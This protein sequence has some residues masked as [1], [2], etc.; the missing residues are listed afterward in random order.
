MSA[1]AV[2]RSLRERGFGGAR[3]AV[4]LGSGLGAFADRVDGARALAFDA[5]DGMPRSAVPGHAGR[6][7]RGELGGVPVL[8]QQG[9]VH[10]YEGWSAAEAT[11]AVR[12]FAALGVEALLLTNA[13]GGVR[14]EWSP[15]T[16]MRV[17]DHLNLTGRVP[18]ADEPR[19]R[20]GAVYDPEV[21]ARIDAA[22]RGAS[23]ALERGV[24]AG[25]LGPSYETPAEIRM[26]RWMG[27]DAVGMST[28]LEAV[29]AAQAGLR[30]AA[31]ACITN[32]A[33]G[34]GT[35]PLAH[36]EVI[37]TG[38]AAAATFERLLAAAIPALRP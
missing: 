6:F 32:H 4:V 29:A 12:A 16:L 35:A 26:A 15:G 7:V 33:A 5:I 19:A 21:G 20:V 27:A 23:V 31:I 38:R 8:V 36:A 34:V 28:V 3:V 14:P 24:Y 11:R 9:R 13:A 37:A 25:L 22:A 30:V 1:D 10:L 2:A 17:T 18:P